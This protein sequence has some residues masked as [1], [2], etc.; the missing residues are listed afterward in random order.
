MLARQHRVAGFALV[1]IQVMDA[2]LVQPLDLAGVQGLGES[3][4]ARRAR[5]NGGPPRKVA[6]EF[7]I[8]LQA[9]NRLGNVHAGLRFRLNIIS[10][11]PGVQAA[12]GL[13]ET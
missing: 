12:N 11:L 9:I 5:G 3:T 4:I 10:V 13:G 6:A 8:A 7:L 2:A 1:G